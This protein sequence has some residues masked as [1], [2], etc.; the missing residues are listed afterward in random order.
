MFCKYYILILFIYKSFTVSTIIMKFTITVIFTNSVQNIQHVTFNLNAIFFSHGWESE[1]WRWGL[2]IYWKHLR[3]TSLWGWNF[4]RHR[5]H[6]VWHTKSRQ[7]RY[8][9]HVK[10]HSVTWS[11]YLCVTPLSDALPTEHM[12]TRGTR[13]VPAL[14]QTQDTARGATHRLA[15]LT[16]T[17]TK[18]RHTSFSLNKNTPISPYPL[19][20]ELGK[21]IWKIH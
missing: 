8:S 6:S 20:L 10:H 16:T 5:G 3:Y 21:K 9:T 2:W 7:S 14:L 11:S 15:R 1:A 12:T 17:H 13:R 18:H 4:S 19:I